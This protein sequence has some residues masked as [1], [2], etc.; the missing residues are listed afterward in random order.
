[1]RTWYLVKVKFAKE[2]EEGLL[3]SVTEQYLVDAVS[4]TEAETIIYAKVGEFVRGDFKVTAMALSDI[5]D[6]FL[7][8]DIDTWYKCKMTFI[9]ID[10]SGKEKKTSQNHLV[11][12]NTT[13]EA[14]ERMKESMSN[15][16]VDFEIPSISKTEILDVFPWQK[17]DKIEVELSYTDQDNTTQTVSAF[18]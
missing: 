15:M 2:N 17:E 4:F 11:T 16:L 1:M 14:Y 13:K 18:L 5:G 6:T 7:Y 10:D 9:G 3:K 8:E 12:A